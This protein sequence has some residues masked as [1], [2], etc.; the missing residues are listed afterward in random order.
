MWTY[1]YQKFTQKWFPNNSI[2]DRRR[3]AL[4]F[5]VAASLF[6][7]KQISR[8]YKTESAIDEVSIAQK[9]EEWIVCW[10]LNFILT[11]IPVNLITSEQSYFDGH[12]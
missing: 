9:T 7:I 8:P 5:G 6:D 10:K 2:Y 4:P 11:N 3:A 1:L 12:Q